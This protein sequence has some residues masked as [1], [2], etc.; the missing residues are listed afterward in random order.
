MEKRFLD[1]HN[2]GFRIDSSF[3]SGNTVGEILRIIPKTPM[4]LK[5]EKPTKQTKKKAFQ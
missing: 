4:E 1:V 5:K 2:A 3:E